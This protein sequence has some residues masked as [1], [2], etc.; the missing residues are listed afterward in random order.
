MAKHFRFSSVSG[1]AMLAALAAPATTAANAAPHIVFAS[2]SGTALPQA[3]LV[4]G[5][6]YAGT[7]AVVQ[8]E[9]DDG[10]MISLVGDVAFTV[11]PD[12]L[13]QVTR[14][15]VTVA[16]G[17]TVQLGASRVVTAS[18]AAATFN[19][20]ADGVNG[21]VVKGTATLAGAGGTATFK[22]GEAFMAASD[23]KP[24][25]VFAAA[26]QAVPGEPRI[27]LAALDRLVSPRSGPQGAQFQQNPALPGSASGTPKSLAA[28]LLRG[29]TLGSLFAAGYTAGLQ[30]VVS[31]VATTPTPTPA[32]SPTP[33]PSPTPAPTPTPT[34][35][36]TPTPTP[37]PTP[38]S[39]T[40]ADTHSDTRQ[41]RHPH[42]RQ[43]RPQPRPRLRHRRRRQ[44]RLRR[45]RRR[46]RRR[47]HPHRRLLPAD[48]PRSLQL[49]P[50]ADRGHWPPP[51]PST[52][53]HSPSRITGPT[54]KARWSSRPP[55]T[56]RR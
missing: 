19:V 13:L 44:L 27:T 54:S 33:T 36:P 15:S 29:T 38:D 37:T 50:I 30:G 18:G 34:P 3:D 6:S 8:I 20:G 40:N 21:R 51:A 55:P 56:S 2:G 25:L 53:A 35:S 46:R 16:G 39:D 48:R 22:A 12:G 17:A 32:P 28:T 4:P 11:L 42:R 7:G 45:R 10:S 23:G 5:Q 9:T 47:R 26:A 43:L 52:P 41:L 24:R 14:G 1:L 31:P 49:P